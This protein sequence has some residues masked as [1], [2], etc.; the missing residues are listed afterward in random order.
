[1]LHNHKTLISLCCL[2]TIQACS[3][4]QAT[5]AQND[6]KLE[7]LEQRASYSYGVDIVNN[8]TKQGIELD[9]EALTQGMN[10]AQADKES[11]LSAKEM[12]TA[13]TQYQ[14]QA[15]EKLLAERNKQAEANL[16]AGKA[17]LEANKTKHGVITTDSGL[18]YKVIKSGDGKTPTA[19]DTVVTHYRGT[20]IDGQEFDSSY[21]RN[22]PATF[23]VK[24]VIK[25]WTEA[26]QL[27]KEGD[28]WELYI[29]SDLAY[30]ES[31]RGNLI[32]PNSALVFE[33]ELLEIK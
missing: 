11:R 23:P 8:L 6:L 17:F 29:P 32:T 26:L 18:Q 25:G 10:D 14:N 15:R 33:I 3:P 1:M 30:G 22:K 4:E 19:N 16:A 28:K 31:A 12:A 24:G 7:S 5:S 2:I 9:I 27:M 21:S 20:L 13:K